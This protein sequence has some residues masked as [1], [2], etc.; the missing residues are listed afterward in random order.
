VKQVNWDNVS[1][2]EWNQLVN[3]YL[4]EMQGS[5]D[6]VAM[7]NNWSFSDGNLPEEWRLATQTGVDRSVLLTGATEA[8]L[9]TFPAEAVDAFGK[10]AFE[11]LSVGGR[12]RLK[13]MLDGDYPGG[14]I[15]SIIGNA[16]ETGENPLTTA[17]NL[18]R[19]FDQY[20]RWEFARLTRTEVAFAQEAGLAAELKAEGY[21]VPQ[22][23]GENIDLPPYHPNCVCSRTIDT[24]SGWILPEVSP[25]ACQVCQAALSAAM[26]AVED[27]VERVTPEE[28]QARA[29]AALMGPVEVS[30]SGP[31]FAL[32]VG[33]E[34]GLNP[35]GIAQLRSGQRVFAK[36]LPG[37]IDIDIEQ[38]REI[39]SSAIGKRVGMATPDVVAADVTVAGSTETGIAET[40]L[41]IETKSTYL[42]HEAQAVRTT[43]WAELPASTADD[44]NRMTVFDSAAINEDRHAANW[45]LA[46]DGAIT[47]IDHGQCTFEVAG[48]AFIV[49]RGWEDD[50][51]DIADDILPVLREEAERQFDI[52]EDVVEDIIEDAVRAGADE[53]LAQ[54]FV[55]RY[56]ENLARLIDEGDVITSF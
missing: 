56:Q 9:D 23:N 37:D 50:L 7:T 25:S 32:P 16:V 55:S 22:R 47:A 4:V 48:D 2:I 53:D 18:S 40:L 10:S 35:A 43:S 21:V 19:R 39:V 8:A 44:F 29:A 6:V 51:V 30:A 26:I 13:V 54:A 28:E 12:S 38:G 45:L 1:Q 34:E 24:V 46:D 17:R 14:S 52:V 41:D 36:V 15:R 33:A 20:E 5:T 49:P 31:D 42:T 27:A 11:R 3:E